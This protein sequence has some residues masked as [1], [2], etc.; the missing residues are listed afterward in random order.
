M[1]ANMNNDF[2]NE[3][4]QLVLDFEKTVLKGGVQFFDVDEMEV[5][6]DYYFEVNDTESLERAVRY[7]EELY[8]DSTTIK[9]RRAHLMIA[10]EQF[11]PALN[12]ILKLREQEPSN[13]DVAYSLGVAYSAVG[14]SRKAI[15]CFLEA[16]NDGWLLGRVY[17]N[18]AEEYFRLR[19]YDEAIRYYHLAL[20]T[21]SFDDTTLINYTDTCCQAGKPEIAVEYLKT[22]VEEHPYNRDAWYCMGVAYREMELFEKASDAFEFAIAIDKTY[23]DAYFELSECQELSGAIGDAVATLMRA[24]DYA[25]DK[26]DIYRRVAYIHVRQDNV[27][28]AMAY[29]RKAIEVA[30][31]DATSY[32]ALALGYATSG[33]CSSAMPLVTKAIRLSPDNPEVLCSAA[34]VYDIQGNFEAAS[35]A[36]ERMIIT[37]KCTE[38]QCQRYTM[39][40]YDHGVYDV[41]IDFALESLEIYPQ[42][43][44]YST[45]LAA[46]YFRTN[47]Y[48]SAAQ[49]MPFVSPGMLAEICPELLSHPRLGALMPPEEMSE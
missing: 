38:P 32:A 3:E 7:A 22:F 15:K 34:M 1:Y 43:P 11:E 33:D 24:R 6:I 28:S 14:E 39:F 21:D 12:M 30:P 4:R 37:G 46:A 25:A 9:L 49:Q 42:H 10:K 44:F 16:A 8:P 20:D 36:F 26:A 5:I 19:N 23:L 47:R 35:D 40:L 48:N 17:D 29:F 2:D 13:T 31:D 27:I 18:I 41:M 45:Y